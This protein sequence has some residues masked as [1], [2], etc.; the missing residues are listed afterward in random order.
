MKKMPIRRAPAAT[1]LILLCLTVLGVSSSCLSVRRRITRT[2]PTSPA[3]LLTADRATLVSVLA[4][5]FAAIHDFNATVDMVPALGTAEKSKI[6]EYKDV[7]GYILFRQPSSIRVIGLLPV[8][9]TKAFDMVSTGPDFK[10]S[11][12]SKNRFVIGK[13]EIT[14][15]SANKIENLRPTHFLNALLVRPI[16]PAVDKL[17]LENFTDEDDAFYILHVV[18]D[19]GGELR[20]TRT[21]WFNRVDLRLARQLILDDNGNI[22]TDARY[23]QWKAY[24]NVPFPKHIEINRPRDEYGVV[25]D[26]VKMDINKGLS[27]DKFVL[28]RPEGSILQDLSQPA[29]APGKPTEPPKGSPR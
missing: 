13:N 21:I 29:A 18:H 20:L 1:L 2:G 5:Q 9:R 14:R 17:L 23:S 16:D 15:P 7:R 27:D 4:K 19:A 25:I 28:E 3:G 22:L 24:D 12:G 6:T 10:L 8:V 26:V 11:I